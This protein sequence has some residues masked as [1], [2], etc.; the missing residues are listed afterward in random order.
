MLKMAKIYT[1]TELT[2][3]LVLSRSSKQV[4]SSLDSLLYLHTQLPN[5][6]GNMSMPKRMLP[7]VNQSKYE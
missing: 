2:K 3:S 5:S 7:N 1:I 4:N 6:F